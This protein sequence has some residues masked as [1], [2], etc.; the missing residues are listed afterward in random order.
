MYLLTPS[1]TQYNQLKEQTSTIRSLRDELRIQRAAV[2][3]AKESIAKMQT[4]QRE[5]RQIQREEKKARALETSLSRA[6]IEDQTVSPRGWYSGGVVLM[7]LQRILE[8][9]KLELARVKDA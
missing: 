8:A 9:Q 6:E 7:V 2:D 3:R 4:E 5:T 1:R